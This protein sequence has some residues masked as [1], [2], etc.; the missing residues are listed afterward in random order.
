CPDRHDPALLFRNYT[1]SHRSLGKCVTHPYEDPKFFK[2][3][4][5]NWNGIVRYAVSP[6]F[7]WVTAASN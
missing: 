2:T 6:A 3:S 4:T 7:S 1:H 5:S